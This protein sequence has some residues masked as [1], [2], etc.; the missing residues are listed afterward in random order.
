MNGTLESFGSFLAL[1][2]QEKRDVF[3]AAASRH[4]TLSNYIE[5]DFWVCLV[6]EVLY[7][8]LP[9]G[10][11]RLH[12]KG[13]TSLSK[14]F[15]FINRFSEDIDLVVNREDLGFVGVS[16][17]TAAHNLSNKERNDLFEKLRE[18]CSK[19]ILGDLTN[20]LTTS[21]SQIAKGCRVGSDENDVGQQTLLI[22]YPTQYPSD[23]ATYVVPRVKI[24]AGAR[25]GL[26]PTLTCTVTPILADELPD[27]SLEVGNLRVIAPERTYW[28]KLL[29]LH[30]LH[31]GYRD[32]RRLPIDN[33]RISRHYYDVAMMSV[34]ES[35]R[36]ALSDIALLDAVR[37]HNLIA[38]RQAW[39]RFEEAVPGSL[40]LVPQAELRGVVESDYAAMEGMILGE[41]P[42]FEW[43]MEQIQ[44]AETTVNDMVLRGESEN[45]T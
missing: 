3:E 27:W 8:R 10:Y 44:Y 40:K 14:A 43:V 30:G 11:P 41:A 36:S 16:D 12:F 26:E 6:L 45:S 21:I 4:D 29:I 31:C 25:S 33:D 35:G 20:E 5:K 22:E 9:D 28:E 38:F 34:R 42:K 1:P 17:P 37:N 2:R 15:G 39:K 18:A 24:E 32:E 7:N 19:Y 23:V 13:G